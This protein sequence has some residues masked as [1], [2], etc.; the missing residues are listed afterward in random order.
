M[1]V[2]VCVPIPAKRFDDIFVMVRRAEEEGA[3]VIEVRLDYLGGDLL[4]YMSR[5]EEV[6]ERSKT[7]LIATNRTISQGGI[8]PLDEEKRLET[9][10]G[11]AR[12][13]FKY[14]DI[15]LSTE[16]LS[17]TI[18][19]IKAYGAEVIVSYHNF[20]G[21]PHIHEM[22]RIVNAQIESGADLCKLVTMANSV[23]DSIR[24]LMFTY[25]L[26]KRTRIICFAM[27]EKG[28]LSR[29]LS[30]LFGSQF[31]YVSLE[32]RLET[33]PGQITIEE[34]REIYRR[35]GIRR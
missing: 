6:V 24:C 22:E 7:P 13:G 25:E 11:A 8:C 10:I 12:A 32:R 5:L 26:S 21:T 23:E 2:R 27:G 1:K 20:E 19:S 35:L 33:A 9:L 3:D 18:D 31:T 17:D 28:L 15:E 14:V 16:K 29:I 34:A 30:P 4:D